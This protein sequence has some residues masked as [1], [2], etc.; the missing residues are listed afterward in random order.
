MRLLWLICSLCASG[1]CIG[2]IGSAHSAMTNNLHSPCNNSSMLDDDE[3]DW[4]HRNGTYMRDLRSIEELHNVS[5]SSG[6]HGEESY[7][8]KSAYDERKHQRDSSEETRQRN[9]ER[10][11][12]MPSGQRDSRLHKNR[13]YKKSIRTTSTP[14]EHKDIEP[15]TISF[16]CTPI[17]RPQP[18]NNRPTGILSI[19]HG[20]LLTC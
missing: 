1:V 16:P 3:N 12:L 4:L 6:F 9:R 5:T 17:I 20:V 8:S 7:L 15:A 19:K 13:E 2:E 18:S 14:S 11:S 10:Y